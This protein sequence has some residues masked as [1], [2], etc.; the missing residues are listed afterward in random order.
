MRHISSGSRRQCQRV[1]SPQGD[2]ILVEMQFQEF[3]TICHIL[4]LHVP[5]ISGRWF[6]HLA[7]FS[8][9]E[10]FRRLQQLVRGSPNVRGEEQV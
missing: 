7:I 2:F 10:K 9:S 4:R 8:S 1:V 6:L 5:D 3:K